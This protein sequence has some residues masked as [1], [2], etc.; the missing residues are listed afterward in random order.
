[1]KTNIHTCLALFTP[2]YRGGNQ[3]LNVWRV[4]AEPGI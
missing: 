3:R 1:M 4:G 2:D